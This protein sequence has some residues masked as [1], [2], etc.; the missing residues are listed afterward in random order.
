MD[1]FDRWTDRRK[2]KYL[3][4]STKTLGDGIKQVNTKLSV[5]TNKDQY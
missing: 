3:L 4:P 5:T 2:V 1:T